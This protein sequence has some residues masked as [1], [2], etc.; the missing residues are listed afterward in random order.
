MEHVIFVCMLS[1]SLDTFSCFKFNLP[2]YIFNLDAITLSLKS[3]YTMFASRHIIIT[4][5]QFLCLQIFFLNL[6]N[7]NYIL[8]RDIV[9]ERVTHIYIC[10]HYKDSISR[11]MHKEANLRYPAESHYIYYLHVKMGFRAEIAKWDYTA[12]SQ[13]N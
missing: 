4:G 3:E 10:I 11:R 1:V 13:K 6:A 9:V 7:I 8:I 2:F 5:I 12:I